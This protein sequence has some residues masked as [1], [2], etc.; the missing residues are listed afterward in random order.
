MNLIKNLILMIITIT[1]ISG[2]IKNEEQLA[3]LLFQ[4]GKENRK[5]PV[6]SSKYP[7]ISIDKAYSIQKYYVEKILRNNT[8][9]GFKAGLTSKAAQKKFSTNIPVAGVLFRKGRKYSGTDIYN[10]EFKKLMI[11]TELG[12]I[13]D[14]VID[15][16]VENTDELKDKILYVMPVIELPDLGFTDLQKVKETDIIAANSASAQYITGEKKNI[17]TFDPDKI[18]IT[19]SFTNKKI[20]S[21]IGSDAMGNQ[22]KALLWLV[23]KIIDQGY[24]I[25][26]GHIL[27]TGA[28]GQVN[29]GNSGK[30]T[31]DYG[32]FGKIGF[33][34]H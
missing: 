25:K 18:R 12:F 29:P 33:T 4:A 1:L 20:N 11:E 19:L 26:P 3:E 31:A 34:I 24:V 27:I 9:T 8:V 32:N 13:I 21:G 5:T 14:R 23:N 15:K 28:L 22:W 17:R 30:Y 16:R 6:L 2:C 7:S 10:N